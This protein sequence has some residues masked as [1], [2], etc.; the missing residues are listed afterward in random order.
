MVRRFS[1]S[2]REVTSRRRGRKTRGIETATMRQRL[3]E[4][5]GRLGRDDA[6]E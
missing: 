2:N 4:M 1:R 6:K 5:V 3:T